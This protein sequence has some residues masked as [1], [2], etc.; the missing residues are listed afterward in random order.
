VE[1]NKLNTCSL[2]KLSVGHTCDVA[3]LMETN[4]DSNTAEDIFIF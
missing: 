2:A 3:A 1:F 4:D